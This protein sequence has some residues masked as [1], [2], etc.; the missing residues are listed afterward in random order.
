MLYLLL[1]DNHKNYLHSFE[2]LKLVDPVSIVAPTPQIA[3]SLLVKYQSLSIESSV[4]FPKL[5]TDGLKKAGEDEGKLLRRAELYL[6]FAESLKVAERE[7]EYVDFHSTYELLSELRGITT[8]EALLAEILNFYPKENAKS[9]LVFN[10]I[11][12]LEGKLDEHGACELLTQKFLENKYFDT[13]FLFEGFVFF[14]AK[15]VDLL[16]A[17]ARHHNVIIPL[18]QSVFAQAKSYDW[19]KWLEDSCEIIS[20]TANFNANKALFYQSYYPGELHRLFSEKYAYVLP[21]KE[22]AKEHADFVGNQHVQFKEEAPIFKAE[23]DKVLGLLSECKECDVFLKKLEERVYQIKKD[24]KISEMKELRIIQMVMETIQAY[25]V[26][27][28]GKIRF[29]MKA[30]LGDVIQ[31]MSPRNFLIPI[32]REQGYASLFGLNQI[33]LL[34]NEKKAVKLVV[35]ESFGDIVAL[36]GLN[37][38]ELDE[39]IAAI[40]PLKNTDFE[41][42]YWKSKIAELVQREGTELIVSKKVFE[43]MIGWIKVFEDYDLVENKVV[44]S[45]TQPLPL[46]TK[47]FKVSN[48]KK[49]G[50]LSATK[51][52]AYLDCPYQYYLKYVASC[53]SIPEFKSTATSILKGNV[54]HK[55]IERYLALHQGFDESKY[56]EIL[57]QIIEESIQTYQLS[58]DGYEYQRFYLEVKTF[59]ENGIK[60]ILELGIQNP[61][62]E[63]EVKGSNVSGRLDL[64]AENPKGTFILD[65]KRSP[66]SVPGVG[67]LKN[68]AKV[69]LWFY[70]SRFKESES[71]FCIGYIPLEK[72]DESLLLTND[73]TLFAELQKL[74][75][76]AYHIID[77]F[78]LK[79]SY[80]VFEQKIVSMIETQEDFFPRSESLQ[81]CQFCDFQS[82]CSYRL[83]G[84][85]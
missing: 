25:P 9:V 24:K 3:D 43:S 12:E 65:F 68:F 15:Q 60:K 6:L 30:L 70:L 31:E 13:S 44:A 51:I 2:Q 80:Q 64:Y 20:P 7:M 66:Y 84:V 54:Q 76:K 61:Q 16:K 55:L 19:P 63:V 75:V 73:S 21:L 29:F 71:P 79:E 37:K 57:K 23:I 38:Q 77:L 4:T 83:G 69:Q 82:L 59:A 67:A 58:L 22:V 45:K 34:A 50:Y 26:L 28:S 14:N 42:L 85:S 8:D 35:D 52:Q 5:L 62:F 40:G 47:L 74:E 10:K 46:P 36:G 81:V 53:V 39:K 27:F 18:S 33:D 49:I 78:S 41:L 72:P 32:R 11:L 17:L 56:Q 48:E 1:Q